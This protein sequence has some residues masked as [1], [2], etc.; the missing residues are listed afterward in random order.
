MDAED[1]L[2]NQA[3]YKGIEFLQCLLDLHNSN[4]TDEFL[5]TFH[6]MQTIVNSLLAHEAE[7][8][9]RPV[10]KIKIENDDVVEL[11]LL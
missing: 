1:E 4:Q 11:K 10:F 6:N 3:I 8:K 5:E 7:I 9:K 2:L